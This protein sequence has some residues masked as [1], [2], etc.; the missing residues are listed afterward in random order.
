MNLKEKFK[1]AVEIPLISTELSKMQR[2]AEDF[3]FGFAKWKD[4]HYFQGDSHNV[5]AKCKNDF[6][7]K[8]TTFNIKQLLEI[9]KKD[10]DNNK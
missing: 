3:A 7:N 1:G 5:Y 6:L 8:E 4:K 10:Y 9:Y 2:I